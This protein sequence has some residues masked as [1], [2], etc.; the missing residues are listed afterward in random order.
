M[1][2][3]P[4]TLHDPVQSQDKKSGHDHYL[5]AVAG[6]FLAIHSSTSGKLS[7]DRIPLAVVSKSPLGADTASEPRPWTFFM[8]RL[9][10][11][12]RSIEGDRWWNAVREE[13]A[14]DRV[15]RMGQTRAMQVIKSITTGTIE[16]RIDAIIARTAALSDRTLTTDDPESMKTFTREELLEIVAGR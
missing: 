14:T 7:R 3:P 1:C 9:Y 10:L 13:Q 11:T 12:R 2:G 4:P 5:A 6:P 8:C 16:E 15:H